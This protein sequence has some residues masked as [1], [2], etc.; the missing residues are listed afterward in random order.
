MRSFDNLYRLADTRVTMNRKIVLCLDNGAFFFCISSDDSL[1]LMVP[2]VVDLFELMGI[3]P[4][5]DLLFVLRCFFWSDSCACEYFVRK[6]RDV[7]VVFRPL[8][9]V[10][11]S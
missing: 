5:F 10:G 1:T 9:V 6:Y 3:N 8:I 4:Y 11:S 7:F 2:D